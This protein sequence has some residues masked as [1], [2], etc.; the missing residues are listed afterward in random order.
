M[1]CGLCCVGYAPGLSSTATLGPLGFDD[2]PPPLAPGTLELF[3][4]RDGGNATRLLHEHEGALYSST[5]VVRL[6]IGVVTDAESGIGAL[7][8]SVRARGVFSDFLERD[9]LPG[10]AANQ[11]VDFD[12]TVAGEPHALYEVML[13]A[14]NAAGQSS[15]LL[16]MPF[17]YDSHPP[18]G[19][20]V[21]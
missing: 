20:R 6:A 1:L 2:T 16:P 15:S 17:M 11:A 10:A 19:G 5:P 4:V 12:A 21:S 9:V 18:V 3:E 13:R 7:D 14:T 8:L